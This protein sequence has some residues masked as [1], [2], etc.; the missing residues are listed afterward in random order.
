MKEYDIIIIGGGGGLK[1]VGPSLKEGKKIAV[2][3]KDL[4]GGTCL[5]RGCIPSK[6]LI[7]PADVAKEIREA[8]KYDININSSNMK[9]NLGKLTSRISNTTMADSN[10]VK[11]RYNQNENIDFYNK[12]C[13]F[14]SDYVLKVGKEEITSKIIVIA[15][16]ARPGVPPIKGLENTPYMTSTQA[17][18]ADKLPKRTI[19]IGGGYIAVELGHAYDSL[20][21]KVT[22]LVRGK[23]VNR[24]D[25]QIVEAF[26]EVF[27]KER[28]VIDINSIDEVKYDKRKKE[29]SVKITDQT[30]KKKTVKSDALLVATGVM[31]NNDLLALDNTS[32]KMNGR[33]IKVDKFM[34]TNV[35]GIYAIGDC[36]GNYMFRHSVNFEA[37]YLAEQIYKKKN[38]K[39]KPIKYLPVPHAIFTNP[40][41]A[42]VGVTEQE[43]KEKGKDYVVGINHYKDSA[44]GQALLDESS[45]VKL[46]FDKKTRKLLGA[47][48]IGPEASNMIHMLI[49][50]ISH[51][52]KH[53]DILD[54]MI[55]VHPA[56]NE[57]VR[58]AARNC[59]HKF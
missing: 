53:E 48:I 50:A 59:K 49:Y 21:S 13:K 17:L 9:V 52:A 34:Q 43:L 22:F 28:N 27:K 42:G 30:N 36:V 23:M 41:I 12:Q 33:F 46:L 16:G 44:M 15:V 2:I 8:K 56:I 11:K 39:K 14:V 26:E 24:E 4:L 10:G 40:Q 38:Q 45:F 19:V 58:N 7:H 6:M 1:L 3:E 55:Y 47:H 35:K 20:G 37:E 57:N 51:G 32:I 5:N 54:K 31:P 29:F 18:K 25:E